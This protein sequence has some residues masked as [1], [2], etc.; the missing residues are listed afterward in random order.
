MARKPLSQRT[1]GI[2]LSDIRGVVKK[3]GEAR[4]RGIEIADFS[5]GTPDLDTP[6]HI[7]EAAKKALDEGLVHYAT[8]VGHVQLRQAICERFREDYE[9]EIDPDEIVITMGSTEAI[10][11]GLQ[12]LF[13]DRQI[14]SS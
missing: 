1:T 14:R 7:K 3:V 4:R 13:F 5:A 8:S 9:L 10:Y 12:D 6:A 11:V 2:R